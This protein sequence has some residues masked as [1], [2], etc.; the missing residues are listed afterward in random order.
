S[1]TGAAADRSAWR[2]AKPSIAL[3]SNAGNGIGATTSAAST[4][5]S[6]R[7]VATCSVARPR[8]AAA[9]RSSS[10][11]CLTVMRLGNA[12]VIAAPLR[13]VGRC[14]LARRHDAHRGQVF[15][16]IE[17]AEA[18]ASQTHLGHAQAFLHPPRR[19]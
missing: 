15:G 17:V 9:A 10:R 12:S 13:W 4:R 6:A 7:R 1:V 18:Y 11:A 3:L 19:K 8:S 16:G 2:T 14:A 5:P